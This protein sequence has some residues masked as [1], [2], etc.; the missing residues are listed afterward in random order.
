[1]RLKPQLKFLC[2]WDSYNKCCCFRNSLDKPFQH[3]LQYWKEHWHYH[4]IRSLLLLVYWLCENESRPAHIHSTLGHWVWLG[5]LLCDDSLSKQ[6]MSFGRVWVKWVDAAG[7]AEYLKWIDDFFL[8][9]LNSYFF[10][11]IHL[12]SQYTSF[13][14]QRRF[15]P[16]FWHLNFY[17]E[18]HWKRF[19]FSFYFK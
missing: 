16:I 12:C 10:L 15:L 14:N 9:K 11:L 17:S 18:S 6:Y 19:K 1:M 5:L 4:N 8:L 13:V 7:L 2:C 3:F